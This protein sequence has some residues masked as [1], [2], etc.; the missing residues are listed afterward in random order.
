MTS[1]VRAGLPPQIKWVRYASGQHFTQYITK[2]HAIACD[3][4]GTVGTN[5]S[6]NGCELRYVHT[7]YMDVCMYVGERHIKLWSFR[8]PQ[9]DG[10]T[11]LMSKT[12]S[13]GKVNGE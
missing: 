13:M 3:M 5:T 7:A 9:K 8:R 6:C 10:P 12:C 4:F 11:S 1:C 2:E